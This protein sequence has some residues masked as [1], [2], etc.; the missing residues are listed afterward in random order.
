MVSRG[1]TVKIKRGRRKQPYYCVTLP[2]HGG[3]RTRRFFKFTPEGKREAETFLQLA[4]QQQSNY[5]TAAF[6]ISDALRAEAVQCSRKLG[7]FGHSLTDAT[8]FFVA[9]LQAQKKSIT[10]NDAMEQ[11][12]T[13]RKRAGLSKRY[14]QDLRLRLSKF[15]KDFEKRTVATITAREIDDWLATLAVAP[16]TRNTFRRD[17]RTL[18]SY[19]EKHGYCQTNEARK[20]E[21]AK[22]INKPTEILTVGQATA[23]LNACDDAILPYVAISLFAGLRAEEVQKLNW[24]EVDFDSSLIEVTAAKAKT[25][26]RRHVPIAENLAAWIRP[27]AKLRGPVTPAGL[28]KRFDKCR[29][30][31]GYGTPGTETDEEK[32]AGV[33]LTKWPQNSMRHS[34]GTYRLEQ[35]HDAARVSLEMGNSPK[36][37]KDHY[38]EIVDHEAAEKYWSLTPLPKH[39]GKI[40]AIAS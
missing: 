13:S 28:R 30:D 39:D 5:G 29:R 17:L 4:K 22:E 15:A 23:L 2:K 34:Y 3:G 33:K 12:I 1:T 19:C 25:R 11:L 6:S 10:V 31:V 18:F 26:Q 37:V 36:I 40:V 9:H 7:E 35:C 14:G 38:F 24:S 16:G 21:R 27:L 32:K 20:T 8:K